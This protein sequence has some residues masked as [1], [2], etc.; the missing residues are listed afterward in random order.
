MN[1]WD[2]FKESTLDSNS[3]NHEFLL[4]D[5]KTYDQCLD[6]NYDSMKKREYIVVFFSFVS[7]S[8]A[9]THC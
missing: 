5:T 1:T 4:Q 9:E 6:Q 2:R 3:F 7:P 8:E